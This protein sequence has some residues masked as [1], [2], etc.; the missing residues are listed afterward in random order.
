MK[1][2]FKIFSSIICLAALIFS[3]ISAFAAANTIKIDGT[4]A[5]IPKG[6]GEIREKDNRTFVPFRFVSEALKYKVW[7][8]DTSKTA[9][10]SSDEKL[11][12]V[13][14]GNLVSCS[15]FQKQP[16]KA[17]R[18]KWT[19]PPILTKRKAGLIFRYAFSPRRWIILSA[20][21]PQA[22]QLHLTAKN[23][24]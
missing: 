5:E 3:S 18:Y 8:D 20:G 19:P 12:C 17:N 7:Y 15:L 2:T 24:S 4:V 10:V 11:L 6:M 14:D 21:M 9:Y 1:K 16:A 22:V 13:Q 23:K